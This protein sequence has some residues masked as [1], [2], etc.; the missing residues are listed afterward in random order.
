LSNEEKENIEK[1]NVEKD[2]KKIMELK[3]GESPVNVRA[4]VLETMESKTIETR[5]GPRTIS[6]AI[7]GD[8]TGRIKTTLWG[9]KAGTLKEGEAVSVEG[10]WTTSYRGKV[11]L[12][13]GSKTEVKNIEDEEVPHSEDVPEEEPTAPYEP[14]SSYRQGQ[15]RGYGTYRQGGYRRRDW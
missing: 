4:R 9:E 1:E 3:Q 12:N 8:D 10:A 15:R 6:E 7:L 14:R 13:I 5:R 11:Q 2:F